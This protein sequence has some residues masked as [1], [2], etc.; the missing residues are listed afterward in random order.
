MKVVAVSL[1]FLLI[2]G[3]ISTSLAENVEGGEKELVRV[4]RN[5]H[6]FPPGHDP[7]NHPLRRD[8]PK[9]CRCYEKSK[10]ICICD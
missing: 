9:G 6:F 5:G 10:R 8:A 3:L 1:A 7:G 4:R 2:A